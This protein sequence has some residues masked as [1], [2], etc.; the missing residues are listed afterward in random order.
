MKKSNKF[1][2]HLLGW[3]I[4]MTVSTH[5]FADLVMN[6]G[7]GPSQATMSWSA[8]DAEQLLNDDLM[9]DPEEYAPQGSTK[10]TTSI[11]SSNGVVTNS[12]AKTVQI[13]DTSKYSNQPTVNARA[14]LVMDGNTGEVLFSKN[15][16]TALPIASITKLMTA[17]VISDARLN[18]SENITLQQADFSCSGCKSSS[19]SLRAGDTM[20]RAE[21]LLFALMKSENPAASV[22]ARTFPGGRSAFI[23]A[24]NSISKAF[25]MNS[26][27]YL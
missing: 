12:T 2:M 18:M 19:S 21:A 24:M 11:R 16:N 8:A 6:P 27:H 22:L 20:N 13:F 23:S 10:V 25:C 1:L 7:S 14:A 4:A 17:V 26:I 9:D 15:S 5:S 3:S